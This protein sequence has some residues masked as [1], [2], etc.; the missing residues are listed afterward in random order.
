MRIWLAGLMGSGK[1]TVGRAL[2]SVLGYDYVD[3]D[4]TIAVKAGQSTV[5]LAASGGTLLHDWES[6][7]IHELV[8]EQRHIVA[9]IPASAADR[10]ADLQ[11]LHKSGAII[12]LR[13]DVDTLAARV[14]ADGPRPWLTHDVRPI[15]EAMMASRDP[16][17]LRFAYDVI[18]GSLPVSAIVDTIVTRVS[19]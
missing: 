16:V 9:G 19:A 15:I 18:D 11:L 13:C 5:E 12:Y 10:Y 1:S 14:Q 7:Y 6:R 8:A 2:A 4:T 3:N 17:Y